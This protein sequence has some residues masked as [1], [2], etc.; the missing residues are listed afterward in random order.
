MFHHA[1]PVFDVF[2][3][4]TFISRTLYK[5]DHC[6]EESRY[7]GPGVD[8]VS[9]YQAIGLFRICQ[10]ARRPGLLAQPATSFRI[11]LANWMGERATRWREICGGEIASGKRWRGQ[12]RHVGY[13]RYVEAH[14]VPLARVR[15]RCGYMFLTVST[16]DWRMNLTQT[17]YTFRLPL[18][19]AD[20]LLVNVS[21][22]PLDHYL[23]RILD[24]IQ[25][26]IFIKSPE[27]LPDDLNFSLRCVLFLVYFRHLHYF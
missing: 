17:L 18:S 2:L 21:N 3:Y 25:N 4:P 22:S 10:Y 14:H 11:F 20:I 9:S 13:G 5:L 8:H 1:L 7:P 26:G 23:G 15:A 27:K 12:C 19:G 6:L 16:S 24:F